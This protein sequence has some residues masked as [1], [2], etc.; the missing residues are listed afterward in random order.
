[1]VVD[2]NQ[3]MA[4]TL[5]NVLKIRGYPA[6]AV[7]SGTEALCRMDEREF[8]WVVSDIK[9]PGITGVELN[10]RVKTRHPGVRFVLMT[11]YS[12]DSLVEQGLGEGAL[13]CLEKPLDLERLF[14]LLEQSPA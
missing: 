2:D 8:D 6:E 5:V 1:L 4:K 12:T 9:M 13:V 14:N 11:A 7:H 3:G 10:R